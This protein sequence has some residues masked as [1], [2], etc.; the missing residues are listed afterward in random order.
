MLNVV[1]LS[2][3]MLS[4]NVLRVV[5][6]SFIVLSL[7][8][9]RI[10]Q[11]IVVQPVIMLNL[12][13]PLKCVWTFFQNILVRTD[14]DGNVLSAVIG[15]FGLATKIPK[16]EMKLPQV[17]WLL[18]IRWHKRIFQPCHR[19]NNRN[20]RQSLYHIRSAKFYSD[21]ELVISKSCS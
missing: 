8:T 11:S 12:L 1:T 7:V 18:K 5:T 10:I 17:L 20:K 13:E 21:C 14:D 9:L 4:A 15:D 3:V 16:P 6:L 2:I 19:E